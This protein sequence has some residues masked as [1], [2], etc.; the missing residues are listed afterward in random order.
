MDWKGGSRLNRLAEDRGKVEV[1][2]T[3]A[4]GEIKLSRH[5]LFAAVLASTLVALWG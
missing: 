2:F 1:Y 4:L 5:Y 3:G